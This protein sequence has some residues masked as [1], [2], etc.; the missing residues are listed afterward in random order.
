MQVVPLQK[1]S[2]QLG[3]FYVPLFEV[4]IEGVGLPRDVLRDVTEISYSDN[5]EEIDSLEM[6]VNN[7]DPTTNAF[8]YIGAETAQDLQGS[9]T[10]AQRFR[11][12]EPCGRE[13]QVHMGYV[14]NLTLMMTGQFTTMEPRFPSGGAP[15][16]TVRG[17][18]VLHKLRR[19]QY[20]YAWE[21]KKD[22]EIARSLNNLNDP[23]D[24]NQRFPLPIEIDDNALGLEEAIEYVTQDNQYD[25]DFL[26]V[27][28]RQRGYVV[29]VREYDDGRRLYFGPSDTSREP[30]T[31]ELAWGQ[32]LMD[33]TPTLTTANQVASVTVNGWN[34][35][36][37]EQISVTVTLDDLREQRNE[38]LHRLLEDRACTEPREEVVVNEPVFTE[39][40]A[41][42][43]ALAI[44]NDQQKVMVTASGTT[45]GLP[46]LRAGRKVK[47]VG[48]GARFSGTYFVTQ[49]TH[50]IGDGGYTTRF[51]ARREDD[52]Q[53]NGG[54]AS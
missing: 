12:F 44:L 17:L 7:W 46:E 34:R 47:I 38:D 52:G 45:V 50:T 21:N 24:G 33:F 10:R 31:Y 36:T 32:S 18:N 4:R 27:R 20:T 49:T 5:I 35:R 43:R 3:G 40:E 16:L 1:A 39:R 30:V 9:G 42:E 51:E 11:L 53:S 2:K 54:G 6:T 14:G 41:R 19:K 22:S 23:D 13:V 25:I 37:K 48:L 8:K 29:Y 28:A 26:L 15:T